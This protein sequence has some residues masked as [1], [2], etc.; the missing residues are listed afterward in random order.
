MNDENIVKLYFSRDEDAISESSN[1]YGAY[2]TSIA[3]NIL[4]NFADVEECVN[5]TWLRAWN[6]I[7]PH[8]P[9]LL[10]VFLGKITRNLAFDKYKA[11]RRQ[12]R[13]GGNVE[14]VLEELAECVSGLDDTERQL[15]EKELQ[16]AI[17]QFLFSLPENKRYL[18][19]LRYW[20]AK[21][22]M[23]IAKQMGMSESN[24]YTSLSRIRG[25]LKAYLLK[26]GYE[27]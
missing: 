12:K 22:V 21:E 18:F 27:L 1:K 23:D 24:V 10:S 14:L 9:K 3:H 26:R 17:D 4:Q 25:E 5:D 20:Y 13:G 8:K 11:L 15:E 7:P 16:E 19:V 6:S 2:C